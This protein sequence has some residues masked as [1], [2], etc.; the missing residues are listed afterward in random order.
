MKRLLVVVALCGASCMAANAKTI[1]GYISDSKCAAKH[2]STSADAACVKACIKGG[3][4]PVFVD[5][6]KNEVWTIDNPS[7]VKDD[8]GQRVTVVAKVDDANKS[9]H[10]SK[11]K[12][13]K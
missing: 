6:A 1:A 12:M 13:A 11:V 7:A 4:N 9:M 8:Y 10:I 3:A 2:T 5:D